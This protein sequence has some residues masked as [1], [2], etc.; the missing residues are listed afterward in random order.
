MKNH[1]EKLNKRSLTEEEAAEYCS[2][3]RSLLRQS[4][5]NGDLEGRISG[6]PWIKMGTRSIRYLI[7]DLD[8]WLSS[9]PKVEPSKGEEA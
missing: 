7:E 8:N 2:I 9:F 3:S 5:M 4:R 1:I 6:P